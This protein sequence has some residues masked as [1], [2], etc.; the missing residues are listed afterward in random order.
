MALP[1]NPDYIEGTIL[2]AFESVPLKATEPSN[3]L[4][5]IVYFPNGVRLKYKTESGAISDLYAFK[6]YGVLLP[7]HVNTSL[8]ATYNNIDYDGIEIRGAL[9]GTCAFLRKDLYDAGAFLFITGKKFTFKSTVD[10][11]G[12]TTDFEIET[13]FSCVVSAS[14]KQVTAIKTDT[15]KLYYKINNVWVK[16]YDSTWVDSGYKALTGTNTFVI[17]DED[18]VAFFDDNDASA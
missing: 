5:M 16:V 18:A 6:E 14:T 8:M 2:T 4:N 13:K 12:I 3:R 10:F 15:S 9:D 1:I 7:F 11:T 17:K